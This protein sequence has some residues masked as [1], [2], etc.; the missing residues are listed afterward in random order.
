MIHNQ[1]ILLFYWKKNFLHS[2]YNSNC[3]QTGKRHKFVWLKSENNPQPESELMHVRSRTVPKTGFFA[4]LLRRRRRRNVMKQEDEEDEEAGR[5]RR[6]L[7]RKKKKRSAFLPFHT[8]C[9]VHQQNCWVHLAALFNEPLRDHFNE[10]Q[11][12]RWV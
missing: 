1:S 2:N 7:I 11:L 8:N 5:R 4:L 9:W 6:E 3:Q 10:P 12:S